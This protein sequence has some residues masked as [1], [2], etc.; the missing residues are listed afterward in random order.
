MLKKT[1]PDAHIRGAGVTGIFLV[2]AADDPVEL[3]RKVHRECPAG[4]GRA[5]AALAVVESQRQ[6]IEEAAVKVGLEHIGR[7]E[8]FCFRL[9]KRGL[10]TLWE[11]TP[12]LEYQ[13][14]GAIWEA[15]YEKYRERPKVDLKVPEVTV[16]AEVL[17]YSTIVGMVRKSWQAAATKE[18]PG[19]PV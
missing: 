18:P 11:N 8:S 5:T 9:H 14:G 16:I 15:L 3:A 19:A 1:L 7:D 2:E 4:I 10:H 6:D 13:I 17:G 12:Q